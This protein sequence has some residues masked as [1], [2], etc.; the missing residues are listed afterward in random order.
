MI[1]LPPLKYISM[2][3]F[4]QMFFAAFTHTFHIGHYNVGFVIV[5]VIRVLVV[6]GLLTVV[7]FLTDACFV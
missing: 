2:P 5:S 4:L 1:V 3:C 7:N 6:V